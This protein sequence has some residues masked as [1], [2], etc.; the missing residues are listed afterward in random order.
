MHPT[1]RLLFFRS[2]ACPAWLAGVPLNCVQLTAKII[3]GRYRL[4]PQ[5]WSPKTTN[6]GALISLLT[7]CFPLP[8]NLVSFSF[9]FRL[10]KIYERECEVVE[11]G[12]QM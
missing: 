8:V 2:Q 10:L 1:L 5:P 6:G 3:P 7:T 4:R 9:N 11:S 12:L